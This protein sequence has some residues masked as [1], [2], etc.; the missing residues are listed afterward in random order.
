M[1]RIGFI[2]DIHGNLEAL[3]AVIGDA[4]FVG[5]DAMVCLGDVIGYGPDPGACLDLVAQNCDVMIRGNHDEAVI[6]ERLAA[7][8]KARAWRSLETSKDQLEPGHLALIGS[9]R[10]RGEIAGLQLA[11]GGFTKRRFQYL[12]D[13]E[14]A[15]ASL[16]ALKSPIGFVGHTHLPSAFIRRGDFGVVESHTLQPNTEVALPRGARVILNPGSV[17]QPRDRNPDASWGVLDTDRW[18]FQARR[19]EYDIDAVTD[20]MRRL[21]LPEFHALRLKAGV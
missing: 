18:V 9:M 19:V 17:G 10:E 15:S 16:D 12:Y 7:R 8:F 1:A 4:E 2:S 14:A 20:R 6:E 11:H 13:G 5:C 21:G 3:G